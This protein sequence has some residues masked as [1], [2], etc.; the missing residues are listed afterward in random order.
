MTR[1]F[2]MGPLALVLASFAALGAAG[3]EPGAG[4]GDVEGTLTVPRCEDGEPLPADY[5]LEPDFFAAD[6]FTPDDELDDGVAIRVQNGTDFSLRGTDA[7]VFTIDN[8][9]TRAL[10][11]AVAAAGTE[12]TTVDVSPGGTVQAALRLYATCPDLFGDFQGVGT[13]TFTSFSPPPDDADDYLR[14]EIGDRLAA[15][16][17]L[18]TITDLRDG[19]SIGALSGSFDFVVDRRP[20]TTG[21]P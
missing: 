17:E 5:A 9:R 4:E 2:A 19:G 16:F 3:C 21:F 10:A 1:H 8:D 14:I 12:G 18:T 6:F 13:I 20:G 11:E 15:T 7:L